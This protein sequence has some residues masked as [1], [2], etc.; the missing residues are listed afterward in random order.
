M[1]LRVSCL[2]KYDTE[3]QKSDRECESQ[4]TF[5]IWCEQIWT[6]WL[7]DIRNDPYKV[8]VIKVHY[9]KIDSKL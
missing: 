9:R 7:K 8:Y 4:P 3:R 1:N 6:I 5:S 2:Q